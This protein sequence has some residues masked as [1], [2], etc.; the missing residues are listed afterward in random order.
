MV[1]ANQQY[2]LVGF[3]ED[4]DWNP[5]QFVNAL[6]KNRLCSLCGLVRK[7][8]ALLPCGHVACSSCYEQCK[9]ADGHVCPIDGQNCLEEDVEWRDFPAE[10]LLNREVQCWNQQHGCT[11]MMAASEVHK[12]FHRECQ[13]HITTCPRCSATVLC[14][15]MGEHARA[16]CN[17]HAAPQEMKCEEKPGHAMVTEILEGVRR[18][19]QEQAH[20]MKEHLERVCGEN[21]TLHSRLIEVS[22]SVNSLKELVGQG[23]LKKDGYVHNETL[24]ITW[25]V[26]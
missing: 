24:R 9:V 26:L 13:Y 1:L 11:L 3:T 5:L 12:H 19:L 18:A 21:G 20:E 15:D 16:S 10:N 17:D 25:E 2:T 4:L 22:Q 23:D 8:T 14:R 7:T 6:P